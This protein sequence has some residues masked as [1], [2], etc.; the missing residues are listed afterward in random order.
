MRD[1]L[2]MLCLLTA[3]CGVDGARDGNRGSGP[4]TACLD[5]GR[6]CVETSLRV[7]DFVAQACVDDGLIVVDACPEEALEG[8]CFAGEP[9]GVWTASYSYDVPPEYQDEAALACTSIG[10]SWT[11]Y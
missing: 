1:V 11:A 7:G 4:F 2:P 8:L 6:A 10:G 3:G 5:E 9:D